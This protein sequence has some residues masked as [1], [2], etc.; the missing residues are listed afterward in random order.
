M[1]ALERAAD[2]DPSSFKSRQNSP[3]SEIKVMGEDSP[4]FAKSL[5]RQATE[6]MSVMVQA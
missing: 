5:H 4:T 6:F 2:M 1:Q 3:P